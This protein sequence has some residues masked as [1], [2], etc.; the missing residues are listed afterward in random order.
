AMNT[1]MP[2]LSSVNLT[3]LHVAFLVAFAIHDRWASPNFAIHDRWMEPYI[4]S[5]CVNCYVVKKQSRSRDNN[6]RNYYGCP[7]TEPKHGCEYFIW[8][9]ELLHCQCGQG[10]CIVLKDEFGVSYKYP[11]VDEKRC[12]Y[13]YFVPTKVL[14]DRSSHT[15]KAGNFVPGSSSSSSSSGNGSSCPN[16]KLLMVK[17]KM[18][19]AQLDL[20]SRH[21][22]HSQF[23]SLH[24][25]LVGLDEALLYEP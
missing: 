7:R 11:G 6:G 15:S 20:A 3:T 24:E 22:D 23:A 2:V 1:K 19:Q 9:D 4:Y 12:G 13:V 5:C 8:E 14:K 18:L 21:E 16:C 25:L 10:W 17:I